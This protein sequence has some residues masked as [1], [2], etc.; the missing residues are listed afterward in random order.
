M[1]QFSFL[2]IGLVFLIFC[3]LNLSAQE[4]LKASA[5]D[6]VL[7]DSSE[8]HSVSKATWLS[9]ALPGAGQYYNESYWKMPILY[10]GLGACIYMA[11]DN[12]RAY[13][14]YL[15]AFFIRIDSTATVTD[16][17]VGIYS[18][19]ELIELQNIYRD[20]RDLAIIIGALVWALNVVDAHVDA[21]LYD[22]NVNDD[23]TL[24]IEPNLF[25][26]NNFPAV[27]LRLS[28]NLQ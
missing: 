17:Y 7:A 24:K 27:G 2:H 16:R 9:T 22:Y 19:R 4:E 10:A 8:V 21:H 23:L 5:A 1:S 13:R 18:E 14:R 15:N 26:V 11:V 3:S 20:W 6:T 25:Y 12:H 28:L